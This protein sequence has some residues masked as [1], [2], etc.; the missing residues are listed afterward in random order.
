MKKPTF[1][2]TDTHRHLKFGRHQKSKQ[3]WRRARGRHSKLRL[4]MAGYPTIPSIGWGTSKEEKGKVRGQTP[5][6]V[7]NMAEL[8]KIKAGE[9]AVLS[10]S[11]GAKKKIDLIK[12]ATEKKIKILNVRESKQ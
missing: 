12:T 11:I 7:H 9:I 4:K 2:R 5:V 1:V 6:L 10:S 3:K 8:T